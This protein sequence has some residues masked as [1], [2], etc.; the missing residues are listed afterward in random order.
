MTICTTS[1]MG[2]VAEAFAVDE[3]TRDAAD[4]ALAIE[5]FRRKHDRLPETLDELVPEFLDAVPIDPFDG[6]PLRY[7]VREDAYVIYS[8]GRDRADDGGEILDEVDEDGW[9]VENPDVI[10]PVKRVEK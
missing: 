9:E 8:I 2:H 6:K 1:Y 5:Q 3:A 7:V 10:F 4:A